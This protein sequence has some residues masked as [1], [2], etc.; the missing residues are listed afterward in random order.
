MSI[1]V[2]R[3][4]RDEQDLQRQQPAPSRTPQPHPNVT[5]FAGVSTAN[6]ELIRD[7][8]TLGVFRASVTFDG[9]G[10]DG[11][12]EY[13]VFYDRNGNVV[14][15][16]ETWETEV[17]D[18]CSLKIDDAGADFNNEGCFGEAILYV[19]SGTVHVDLNT[20]VESSEHSEE[21]FSL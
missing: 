13:P 9:S 17:Y 6:A 8:A 16:E 18:L 4:R 7:L 12:I 11:S 14:D 21:T 1:I 10:D 19:E 20:R 5:P 15:L 3:P 2:P